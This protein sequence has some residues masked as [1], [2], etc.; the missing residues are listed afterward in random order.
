[1]GDL[2]DLREIR[3]DAIDK[4]KARN[5]ES[6]DA[7]WLDAIQKHVARALQCAAKN[8]S[9]F[10]CVIPGCIDGL[11]PQRRRDKLLTW[12]KDL[13]FSA[14]VGR[15]GDLTILLYHLQVLDPD[16]NQTFAPFE[17]EAYVK[18]MFNKMLDAQTRR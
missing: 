13:G 5:D 9:L 6:Q 3:Q 17:N 4:Q 7:V 8:A 1:M 14:Q 10:T 18:T 15:D 2:W 16:T 11:T 12:L